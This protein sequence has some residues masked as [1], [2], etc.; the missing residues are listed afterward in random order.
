MLRVKEYRNNDTMN[1]EIAVTI[2]LSS[3][4]RECINCAL[5][6]LNECYPTERKCNCVHYV[7][8]K[9]LYDER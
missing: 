5:F 4:E 1:C 6:A 2:D 3:N 9:E 8:I 7:N